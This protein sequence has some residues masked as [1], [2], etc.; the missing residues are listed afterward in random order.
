MKYVSILQHDITDCG[1]AACL[2]VVCRQY[3]YKK[4]ISVI[5]EIAG[6]DRIDSILSLAESKLRGSL[7]FYMT[8]F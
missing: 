6:T 7:R 3:G 1:G 8:I 4:S 5:R 2:A